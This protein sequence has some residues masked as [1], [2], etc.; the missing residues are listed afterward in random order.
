GRITEVGEGTPESLMHLELDRQ[1]TEGMAAVERTI[2]A[3]LDDVRSIVGDWDAMRT[4]M[5][6]IAD[7]L[8][9][10]RLPVSDAGRVEAQEFL[11]WAADNHFTYFGYREYEVKG[12]TGQEM[13]VP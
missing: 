3:V 8:P 2:R 1:P 9:T 6:S 11:R 13:L 12:K 7:E 10:R 4:R 5:L